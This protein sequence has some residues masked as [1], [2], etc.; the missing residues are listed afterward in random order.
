MLKR[1]RPIGLLLIVFLLIGSVVVIAV[2]TKDSDVQKKTFHALLIDEKEILSTDASDGS[3]LYIICTYKGGQPS[4]LTAIKFVPA[5]GYAFNGQVQCW[6][7]EEG[8]VE[9]LV[10]G[11]LYTSS[12]SQDAKEIIVEDTSDEKKVNIEITLEKGCSK[13]YLYEHGF[14]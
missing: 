10:N 11:D 6:L 13:Y 1:K 5:E 8:K 4:A 2:L 3:N 9:Y 7:R 12:L 14:I